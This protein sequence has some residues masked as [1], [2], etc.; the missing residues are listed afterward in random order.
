MCAVNRL[1]FILLLVAPGVLFAQEPQKAD[2]LAPKENVERKIEHLKFKGIAL[3]GSP[4]AFLFSLKSKG[5]RIIDGAQKTYT[6][7][8][9]FAGVDNALVSVI[10]KDFFVWKVSVAFPHKNSWPFVREQY[11]RFKG[12]YTEKYS[13]TP[14]CEEKLSS[15]YR[16]GSGN[17]QWGFESGESKWRSFFKLP[18]GTIILSVVYDNRAE[19]LCVVIDYIDQINYLLKQQYELEDL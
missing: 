14:K 2:S 5:F 13:V 19:K 7:V 11:E 17:E 3:D 6:A 8:G 12:F 9:E 10:A 4:E 16:D 1:F 15:R 18:E